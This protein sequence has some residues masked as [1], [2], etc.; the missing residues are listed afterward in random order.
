MASFMRRGIPVLW[1]ALAL[2]VA[3]PAFAERLTMEI[4]ALRH[5]AVEEAITLIRPLV[6]RP[7]VVTGMAGQ[8]VVLTTPANME[9]VLAVLNSLDTP[10]QQ[11]LISVRDNYSAIQSRQSTSAFVQGSRSGTAVTV[12]QPRKESVSTQITRGAVRVGGALSDSESRSNER[13]DFSIRVLEGRQAFIRIGRSVPVHQVQRTVSG[14]RSTV[15]STTKYQGVGSGFYV[16]PRMA[17]DEVMLEIAPQ[18]EQFSADGSTRSRSAVTALRAPIGQWVSI[19]GTDVTQESERS[20]IGSRSSGATSSSSSI[21]LK[22]I[23]IR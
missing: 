7:G 10:P 3:M 15:T 22:V 16:R 8:L 9:Q 18:R 14:N 19:G 23:V 21:E 11:F 2:V 4:I 6:P 13:G 12:G 17:G 20:T 1:T 5:R